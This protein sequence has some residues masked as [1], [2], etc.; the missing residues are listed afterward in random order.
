MSIAIEKK[1]AENSLKESI[2]FSKETE[3]ELIYDEDKSLEAI[4]LMK[5][6]SFFK[7]DCFKKEDLDEVKGDGIET[8]QLYQ[9]VKD[10]VN[11]KDLEYYED[12]DMY[13]LVSK[14]VFIFEDLSEDQKEHQ[15]KAFLKRKRECEKVN[16]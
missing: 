6:I 14:R 8:E 1:E 13:K 3:K 9:V 15:I 5:T 4:V 11:S 2:F 16:G 10:L 7:R 12:T